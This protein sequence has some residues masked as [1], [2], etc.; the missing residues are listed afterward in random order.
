MVSHIA[1]PRAGSE[2]Q[3]Y[4]VSLNIFQGPSILPFI[5]LRSMTEPSSW[6][7]PLSMNFSWKPVLAEAFCPES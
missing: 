6:D 1:R 5:S 3:I 4:C 2:S 7:G